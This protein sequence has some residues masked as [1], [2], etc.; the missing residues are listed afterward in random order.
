MNAPAKP[1]ALGAWRLRHAKLTQQ[2]A[3]DRAGI[4]HAHAA[5]IEAD[6]G[7]ATVGA[8]ESYVR[9]C[10]GK[11][12]CWVEI[13]GV[14]RLLV[15]LAALVGCG[16]AA[17]DPLEP[18]AGYCNTRRCELEVTTFAPTPGLAADTESILARL[19]K[20]TGRDDLRIDPAGVPIRYVNDVLDLGD[21]A[22]ECGQTLFASWNNGAEPSP[23]RFTQEIRID[24]D[25]PE[26][27]PRPYVALMHEFIHA[28]APHAEHVAPPSLFANGTDMDRFDESA[29]AALCGEFACSAFEPEVRSHEQD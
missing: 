16:G 4:P 11:L 14:R 26:G 24:W 3:A 25:P 7:R 6:P 29:A 10:G 8:V 17:S 1:C 20:V 23:I 22:E 19:R 13:R 21:G 18:P 5:A 2:E 28:L 15:L 9:A 12:E 27:C